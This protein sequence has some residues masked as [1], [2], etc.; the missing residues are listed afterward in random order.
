[1]LKRMKK[2]KRA[3]ALCIIISLILSLS[4]CG[5]TQKPRENGTSVGEDSRETSSVQQSQEEGLDTVEAVDSA[6]ASREETAAAATTVR[7]AETDA[8]AA[9]TT[10]SAAETAANAAETALTTAETAVPAAE[11][12]DSEAIP[13]YS[14]AENWAYFDLGE[15]KSADLFLV[16]PTVDTKDEYNMSMNDEVVKKS[17]LG[18]LNMER[19][20]YEDCTRMFAPYYRQAALKIYD[21]SPEDRE[22][23]LELAYKDVSAAFSWYLENRNNGRPIVLAGFSQGADMCY[24]I[25]KEYFSDSALQDQLVAVYA[26]GWPMTEEMISLNPQIKPAAAEDDTGVVVTFECESEEL[27]DKSLNAGACFTDYSGG[28]RR[29]VTGLCGCYIDPERGVLKVT[30]VTPEEFPPILPILPEGSYHLYDYQFFFRNLQQNVDCRINSYL[31][32]KTKDK[33]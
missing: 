30:D 25:L 6:T 13:D 28:I 31:R 9:D 15:Q 21:L 10:E 22:P 5:G 3:A 20:I 8:A 24:R 27:A 1:M 2:W 18:A 14:K 17:F 11:T 32:N 33:E 19:G 7:A 4:A 16:C 29:E 23:Y 26:I 12:A